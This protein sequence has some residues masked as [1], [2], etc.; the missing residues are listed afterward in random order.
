[1]RVTIDAAQVDKARKVAAAGGEDLGRKS[2]S[3][4]CRGEQGD[5]VF[6][7]RIARHK[8]HIFPLTP[9]IPNDPES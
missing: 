6:V 9:A 4:N 3:G 7:A 1:M 5:V 8:Y 2:L